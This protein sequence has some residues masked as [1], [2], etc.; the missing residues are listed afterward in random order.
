MDYYQT[1][2]VGKDAD[3]ATIKR[4]YRKLASQ[5]H[6]DKGGNADMF[7]QVQEA[8]ETL[9]D[10]QKRAQYDN[11]QP[12]HHAHYSHHYGN[13]D[14]PPG[15]EDMFNDIFRHN[16]RRPRTNPDSVG[17]LNITLAQAYHG[18]TVNISVGYGN[19]T[20]H[21]PPGARPGTKIRIPGR[22]HQRYADAPPG[23]LIVRLHIIT[24]DNIVI[25]HNDIYHHIL[26]NSIEAMI[27]VEKEIHHISGKK[28]KVKVP[29]GTQQDSRLRMMGYGMPYP[30]SNHQY[31]NLYV[32]VNIATPV[33]NKQEHIDLLNTINKEINTHERY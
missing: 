16:H 1:L 24:P 13:G 21:I 29:A 5:H 32:I 33:I 12:Q 30:N 15:F 19:E 14:V 20:V 8:Y 4:A 2:G 26:I 3:A 17:D 6:P 18:D 31:G 23:D 28:L 9:S 11:P 7:K 22:G 27:G 10:P 25:D